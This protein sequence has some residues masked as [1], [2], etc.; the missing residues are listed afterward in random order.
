MV[1][2][3][4][5]PSDSFTT[6]YIMA[7]RHLPAADMRVEIVRLS[8]GPEILSQVAAG[9]LSMG[10]TGM[11]AAGFNAVAS[12]LPVDF[13]APL[14]SGYVEDYF[15][16]RKATCKRDRSGCGNLKG[17]PWR[18]NIRGCRR[19]VDADQALKRDGLGLKDVQVKTMSARTCARESGAVEAA[20]SHRASRPWLRSVGS[21]CDRC[22]GPG[23]PGAKATPIT[24]IF[25]SKDW[26]AKKT[27]SPP[28][29]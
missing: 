27:R 26:A 14:H 5:I 29:R 7:D 23:L 22:R 17:K 16:V 9:Q 3:G 15:T 19:R 4:Y 20:I 12:S 21:R 28:T 2:V 13:V 18:L 1:K 25:W 10:G 11:G 6:L 24:A 8:G